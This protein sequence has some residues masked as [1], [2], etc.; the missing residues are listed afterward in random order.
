MR[1]LVTRGAGDNL[2][3]DIIVDELCVIQAVGI[4]RGKVFLYDEGFTKRVYEITF[5]YRGVIYPTDLIALHDSSVGESFVGRVTAHS[6]AIASEEG[7]R[8]VQSTVTLERSDE[9]T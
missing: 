1:V 7:T 9:V 6:I 4:E 5:P 2:A 8:T 3:P